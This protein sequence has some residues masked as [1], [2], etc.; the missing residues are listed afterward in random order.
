MSLSNILLSIIQEIYENPSPGNK[1]G[2][3]STLG[4]SL[5][6]TQ[7]GGHAI[8]TDVIPY[9]QRVIKPGL[10]L[11]ESSGN[12]LVSGYCFSSRGRTYR[13]VHDWKR[14]TVWRSGA[15]SEDCYE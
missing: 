1:A 8:V 11:L 15:N 5:G 12:D 2:G 9:G 14:N 13:A 6:C 7:K 4:K 10:N 3:I